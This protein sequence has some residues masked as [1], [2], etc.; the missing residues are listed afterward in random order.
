MYFFVIGVRLLDIMLEH[1]VDLLP[2]MGWDGDVSSL[3]LIKQKLVDARISLECAS[4]QG[5][6]EVVAD[7]EKLSQKNFLSS[8]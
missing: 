2:Y 6:K 7:I 1:D 5:K 8:R 4:I 3:T